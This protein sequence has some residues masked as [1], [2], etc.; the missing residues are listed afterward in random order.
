M[1]YYNYHVSDYFGY[2]Q[3]G[4]LKI[5]G[6]HDAINIMSKTGTHLTW[7]YHDEVFSSYDWTVE[8]KESLSELYRKRAEQ[9]RDKY[10]YLILCFSGGADSDNFLDVFDHNNIH[11][12]EI[13]TYYGGILEKDRWYNAELN[14][15]AYPKAQNYVDRHPNTKLR[16]IDVDDHTGKFWTNGNSADQDYIVMSALN[17]G[18]SPT[19]SSMRHQILFQ[20][21]YLE[22]QNKGKKIGFV[23]GYDKPRVWQIDGKYCHRFLDIPLQLAIPGVN[24]PIEPFYW[25]PDMPEMLIKQCHVIK[26]YLEQ[27]TIKS[28]FITTNKTH[29]SCKEDG[30][31]TLWL[32]NHGVHHLIYPTWDV[33]TFTVG[34]DRNIHYVR[35]DNWVYKDPHS[36]VF[37]NWNKRFVQIWKDTPE[38]WK[39]D[40]SNVLRGFKHSWTIPYYLE[41]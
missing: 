19:H 2:Y 24:F 8:P 40:P 15:V 18:A 6:K 14:R 25:A 20:P 4:D 3:V 29:F 16:F 7:H 12:D 21:D 17:I 34:K 5:H 13:M 31:T 9:L 36:P 30:D 27:A 10:D 26:N 1:R 28:P 33:N 35:R 41:R 32:T 37:Q 22:L 11:V 39:N 23:V 38:Y